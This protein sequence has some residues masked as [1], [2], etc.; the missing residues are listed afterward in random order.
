MQDEAGSDILT[1]GSNLEGYGTCV[2]ALPDYYR[3]KPVVGSQ[4][5]PGRSGTSGSYVVHAMCDTDH[6]NRRL[7]M[8][9]EIQ[10]ARL[11]ETRMPASTHHITRPSTLA[12]RHITL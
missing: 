10:R 11:V 1:S 5:V 9:Y 6:R 4:A 2:Q 3:R 8:R 12:P 7:V